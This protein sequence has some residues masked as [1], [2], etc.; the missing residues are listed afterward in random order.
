MFYCQILPGIGCLIIHFHPNPV[1]IASGEVK[2][3]T[4]TSTMFYRLFE[5]LIGLVPVSY[6]TEGLLIEQPQFIHRPRIT[7]VCCPEAQPYRQ[8]PA[9]ISE[10]SV[11]R[12]LRVTYC[13]IRIP[14]F[15]S[16]HQ[17]MFGKMQV[18][19]H[20]QAIKV[21]KGI[22]VHR[23]PITFAGQVSEDAD[24][25][26]VI[27]L[28][29]PAV[30]QSIGIIVTGSGITEFVCRFQKALSQFNV[31]L[32]N[33]IQPKMVPPFWLVFRVSPLNC[34]CFAHQMEGSSITWEFSVYQIRVNAQDFVYF[35]CVHTLWVCCR[36]G[37]RS[38]PGRQKSS[39]KK[40]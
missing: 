25:S 29:K 37:M 2:L 6:Y 10:Y 39:V 36:K 22:V 19:F 26:I 7:T 11:K 30:C 38:G 28:S 17:P 32:L 16:L 31:S 24:S 40:C 21:G 13:R 35:F 5:P 23:V 14:F 27:S 1:A 4:S 12:Q 3:R 34:C 18:L 9:R 15:N 33:V 8:I 20:T